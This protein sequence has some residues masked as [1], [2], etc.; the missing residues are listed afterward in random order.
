V[1]RKHE[2]WV[3]RLNWRNRS[4]SFVLLFCVLGTH[5]L[6]LQ[7]GPL[8]WGLLAL[9]ML[10]SPQL[11]YWV[12]RRSREQVRAE[13]RNLLIDGVLFGAWVGVWGFPLWV[14]FMLFAAACMNLMIYRGLAGLRDAA[15][16]MT[17]GVVLAMLIVGPAFRPATSMLTTVLCMLVFSTY[18]LILAYGAHQ[19]GVNLRKSRKQLRTQLAEITSLQAQLQDQAVRDPLTGLSNRRHLDQV[20]ARKLARSHERHLPLAL[21]LIDIDDFKDINDTY[22]HLAGDEMIKAMARLLLLSARPR[23]LVCRYGGEEFLLLLSETSMAQAYDIADELRAAFERLR[24]E[25]DGVSMRATLSFG[26][27]AF[28]DHPADPTCLVQMAD[29]AL[30]AAKI[31][32]RNRGELSTQ[33]IHAATSAVG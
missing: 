22:G 13:M 7:A 2:H 29:R 11:A 32:G 9:H 15:A 6:F 14:S 21:V 18:L 5:L 30:Y 20:L 33:L 19:R 31:K 24:V 8:M 26:V 17:F 1:V 12:A 23:D 4:V 3:V 27:S 28:P 10:V 25:Y 16:S